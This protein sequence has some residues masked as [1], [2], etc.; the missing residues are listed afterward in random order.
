MIVTHLLFGAFSRSGDIVIDTTTGL[1]WQDDATVATNTRTW[2]AAIDYCENQLTLGGYDDW[3]LPNKKELLSITDR[4]RYNPAIDIAYFQ[5][6]ALSYYWS[7]TTL[8]S[9][10]PPSAWGV[11]FDTSLWHGYDYKTA[12]HYLRCVRGEPIGTLVIPQV[13]FVSENPEDNILQLEAFTKE[14]RFGVD[15]TG[16]G[17]EVLSSDF[18]NYGSI[19]ISGNTVSMNVT[20]N[21]SN[22]INTITLQLKDTNDNYV[23]I[24]NSETF[25]AT[26]R[27]GYAPRLADGQ[28]QQMTG[29]IGET[30]SMDIK[31]YDGDGDIVS[32]SVR[33][34]DGGSVSFSGN[35]LNVS[36]S[37]SETLHTITITL[38]DGKESVDIDITVLRFDSSTIQTFY[39]DVD[40]N[41]DN[42]HFTDLAAATLAGIVSGEPDPSDATQRIFRPD[43][44]ASMAEVLSMVIRAAKEAGLVEL[45]SANYYWD[46]YP[47]SSMPYYTFARHTGAVSDLGGDL[48]ILYPSREEVAQI[49]TKVLGLDDKLSSFPD[50]NIIFN[51]AEDFSNEAMLRYAQ[52]SRIYG[53]FLTSDLAIPQGKVS[54]AEMTTLV[55]KIL[56]MPKADVVVNP[57]AIEFGDI[58]S[59]GGKFDSKKGILK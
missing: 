14:W 51:D 54:R 1:Q 38:N 22:I 15:L 49:V 16:Y 7:S 5:N 39:S 47:S 37:D 9:F 12:S 6:T 57:E 18:Y 27:S 30:L 23:K 29:T 8:A 3:R 13:G 50:I 45:V 56:M 19:N 44:N 10:S 17:V 52:I 26:V 58:I 24:G 53:L 48:S 34:S 43:D 28:S 11:D 32:L 55:T 35:S 46:A 42:H 36:F 33:N 31:T 4:S 41:T 20:P 2:T 21:A 59:I 25:W 40:P